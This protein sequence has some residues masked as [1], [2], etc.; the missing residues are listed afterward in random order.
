MR[1]YAAFIYRD[2]DETGGENIQIFSTAQVRDEFLARCE[3]FPDIRAVD[4]DFSELSRIQF[5]NIHILVSPTEPEFDTIL[6]AYMAEKLRRLRSQVEADVAEA[7]AD[8]VPERIASLFWFAQFWVA[9]ARFAVNITG[10]GELETFVLDRRNFSLGALK[11][12]LRDVTID[13]RR[14]VLPVILR[15]IPRPTTSDE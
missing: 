1:T 5:H 12:L 4:V 8:G 11:E 3:D 9:G 14:A 6:R 7:I 10:V 15:A 2:P 13:A